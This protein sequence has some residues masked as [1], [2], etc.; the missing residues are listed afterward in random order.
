M[1]DYK[2][3]VT[4][5]GAAILEEI[6]RRIG[7]LETLKLS[8]KELCDMGEKIA[9]GRRTMSPEARKRISA[10]QKARWT[11]YRKDKQK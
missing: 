2:P 10:A 6:E 5:N 8:I 4:A 9:A 11:K 1:K 7:K 3:L